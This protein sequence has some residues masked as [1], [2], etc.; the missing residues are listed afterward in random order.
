MN[1]S[2]RDILKGAAATLLTGATSMAITPLAASKG[3]GTSTTPP[4][5][6][7][8][9]L[10]RMSF[11]GAVGTDFDVRVGALEASTL[12]LQTVSDLVLPVGAPGPAPGKEGFSLLF[13]GP[14]KNAFAQG[15]YTIEHPTLGSFALFLVP[16]GPRGSTSSYE[17]VINRL[18]P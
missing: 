15:T 7:V 1:L 13:T 14:S 6:G 16:V 4:D 17:A 2:R 8:A 5:T 3:R 18:W 11:T 10:S 12:R 9:E